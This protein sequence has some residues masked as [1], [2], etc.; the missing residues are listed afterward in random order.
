MYI[1]QRGQFLLFF[2]DMSIESIIFKN[3]DDQ[4]FSSNVMLKSNISLWDE[5]GGWNHKICFVSV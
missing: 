2:Y 3:N 5:L 1:Q 4:I